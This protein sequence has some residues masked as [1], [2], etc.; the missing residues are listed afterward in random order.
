MLEVEAKIKVNSHLPIKELLVNKKAESLG[1]SVQKDMYFNAPDRDFAKTDEALRIRVTDDNTEI[2]YKGPKLKGS[3]A[4]ARE[5]FNISFNDPETLEK[6]LLRLGYRKS[7]TVIKTREEYRF[8]GTTI[9]L[10]D[11]SGIGTFVEIEVVTDDNENALSLI[12][13]AKNELGIIGDHITKSY[14]EMV[15]EKENSI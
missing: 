4:K 8:M 5:E 3:S 14:L 6:I 2:T 1:K 10:D 7:E 15:L 13:K 11:I 9:A 12:E